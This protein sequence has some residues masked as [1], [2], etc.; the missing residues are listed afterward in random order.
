M[1]KI[2][3]LSIMKVSEQYKD[4]T[5]CIVLLYRYHTRT[6]AQIFMIV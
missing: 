5:L 6:F 1:T 4:N 2:T 3:Q